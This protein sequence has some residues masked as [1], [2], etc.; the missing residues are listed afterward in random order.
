MSFN[1]SVNTDSEAPKMN[2]TGSQI[3]ALRIRTGI[4]T[5][6][7]ANIC[8][9]DSIHIEGAELGDI[10]MKPETWATLHKVCWEIIEE[11]FIGAGTLTPPTPPATGKLDNIRSVRKT[12]RLWRK[13]EVGEAFEC[14]PW[15]DTRCTTGTG[16][17]TMDISR[18]VGLLTGDPYRA[19]VPTRMTAQEA[20][21]RTVAGH[22][23][24]GLEVVQTCGNSLCCNPLHLDLG[25]SD[26]TRR[27][28]TGEPDK[29]NRHKK[30]ESHH[31]S[32]LTQDSI[33]TIFTQRHTEAM[34]LREISVHHNCSITSIA[35]VLN[36][37]SWRHLGIYDEFNP[38]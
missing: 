13:I 28:L 37:K 3:T 15:K 31:R 25:L 23:P 11:N 24:I 32:K 35:K 33:R 14:W 21:Y 22:V 26:R 27:R 30:G 5:L 29:P 18:V 10:R 7:V 9:T 36:G 12:D 2:P 1:E 16:H 17:V 38:A 8:H 4:P 34:T 6:Q 19:T 20:V